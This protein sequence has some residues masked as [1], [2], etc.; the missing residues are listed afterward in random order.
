MRVT[1]CSDCGVHQQKKI[2]VTSYP[3]INLTDVGNLSSK[4]RVG[5]S[6]RSVNACERGGVKCLKSGSKGDG[7]DRAVLLC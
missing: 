3:G 1:F 5:C 7:L 6:G 2:T 4:R